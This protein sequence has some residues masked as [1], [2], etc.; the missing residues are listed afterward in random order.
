MPADAAQRKQEGLSGV[1]F[2]QPALHVKAEGTLPP[3]SSFLL[4]LKLKWV[5]A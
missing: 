3:A 2:G 4:K 5:D 1:D